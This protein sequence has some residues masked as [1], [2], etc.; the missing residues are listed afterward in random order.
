MIRKNNKK[1]IVLLI[2]LIVILILGI[3]TYFII[4]RDKFIDAE[5]YEN[6]MNDYALNKIYEN[7]SSKHNQKLKKIEALKGVIFATT[8]SN[9]LYSDKD[10]KDLSNQDYIEY[11]EKK[12]YIINNSITL[13]NCEKSATYLDIINLVSNAKYYVLEKD[14]DDKV[15]PNFSNFEKFTDEVKKNIT[16]LVSNDILVNSN[17]KFNINKNVKK[18]HFNE[19]LI[20]YIEKFNLLTS[21]KSELVLEED[22]GPSNK[23]EYPYIL[24]EVPNEVYEQPYVES[25]GKDACNSLEY[26][27]IRKEYF[28][29]TA[30]ICESYYNEI[31]NIDYKTI[32]YENLKEKLKDLV[33]GSLKEEQLKK[34]I[35]YVKNN[36]IVLKGKATV[37]MP[38]IY[39]DG[40]E[41]IVRTK[42]EFE[43]VES[44]TNENV[45]YM[46]LLE[47]DQKKVYSNSNLIYIDARLGYVINSD[48]T[49]IYQYPI[50]TMLLQMSK[51][52]IEIK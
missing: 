4:N 30:K 24:K 47:E 43:I 34:Y 48:K 13:E 8:G 1:K 38:C 39:Y 37:Q 5:M 35:E 31:L 36:K 52:K 26:Y 23:Q 49:Y 11:G 32:S 21:G 40:L 20:K 44:N 51:D 12:G 3:T 2:V 7:E 46:D 16:D 17:D 9:V 29:I 18:G 6:K 50:N 33:V 15:K 28:N 19:M 45:L 22:K 25:Q 14:Y 42:L 27:K 10:E 41:N